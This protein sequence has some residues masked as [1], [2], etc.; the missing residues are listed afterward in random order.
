MSTF[1][2]LETKNG[3]GVAY[4]LKVSLDGFSTV[5][6]TYSTVAV[7]GQTY[8]PRIQYIGR[9][10]RGLQPQF[11]I[12][13]GTVQIVLDNTDGGVDWLADQATVET[14]A[15]QAQ[16][17]LLMLLFDPLN[18]SDHDTKDLG[19]WGCLDY[20]Q[21]DA[22]KVTLSLADNAFGAISELARAPSINEWLTDSGTTTSNCPLVT[23]TGGGISPFYSL[24][25]VSDMNA[26]IR[27]AFGNR[28]I[29][30]IRVCE[31]YDTTAA[32]FYK[33]VLLVCATADSEPVPDPVRLFC[34]TLGTAIADARLGS[35]GIEVPSSTVAGRTPGTIWTSNVSQSLTKDGKTWTIIYIVIDFQVFRSWVDAVVR[36]P[37][38][39]NLLTPDWAGSEWTVQCRLFSSLT[40][41]T[42]SV[43]SPDGTISVTPPQVAYD[44]LANYARTALS[45]DSSSFAAVS[46]AKPI[47]SA[48]GVIG[49][50]QA[51]SVSEDISRAS[52]T[53]RAPHVEALGGRMKQA[54]NELCQS[55]QFDIT[56]KWDGT[57]QAIPPVAS[58]D[59]QTSA[60]VALD[61]ELVVEGS[62]ADKT[63]SVGERWSPYNRIYVR[64]P[65]G[66][67]YGPF[68]AKD[69][70]L[71]ID[72]IDQWGV[73]LPY[74]LTS[75]WVR[76]SDVINSALQIWN[77]GGFE[78]RVRPVV[79]FRY[80]L[81]AMA[82]ELGQYIEL[83]WSRGG[84]ISAPYSQSI[85]RVEGL[86][87]IPE[88]CEMQVTC[89]WFGDL[90]TSPPYLLDNE[91]FTFRWVGTG[92][93]TLT[94]QDSIN[95][96]ILSVGG[97]LGNGVQPG[98]IIVMEDATQDAATFTRYRGIRVASIFSDTVAHVT[99][100]L[101]FDAPAGVA[102]A[103]GQWAI[104]RGAT[105][106]PDVISDPTHYPL[107]SAMYGKVT[108]SSGLYSDSTTGN[109]LLDG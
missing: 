82:L 76:Y 95:A 60:L 89:V 86:T 80:S 16:F 75:T 61:E 79:V 1:A 28:P 2:Q 88:S 81:E 11:T 15:L 54:L 9:L 44:L 56:T 55:G 23:A 37:H 69:Y 87:L 14:E 41:T 93:G 77:G 36:G 108:D 47:L 45:V 96:V 48:C 7:D 5:F 105:T 51:P 10:Q 4:V 31:G 109:Q 57:I 35:Q 83:T 85:F 27:L 65:D 21:R 103:N 46:S 29:P 26:P 3:I 107:G 42:P 74:T 40:F 33:R 22:D 58:F 63:P 101:G 49:D 78:A 6:A 70:S 43:S 104:Y 102:I 84:T 38:N 67:Q 71:N 34:P 59:A 52:G 53:L 19:K 106:Y 91:S 66:S 64:D 12:G 30:G 73:V 32:N 18:P 24:L 68:D 94:V 90:R 97:F 13:A 8:D 98:D 62:W 25:D 17:N 50:I 99:G 100:D 72:K 20:P 92:G 39:Q